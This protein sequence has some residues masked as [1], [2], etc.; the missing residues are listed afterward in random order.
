MYTLVLYSQVPNW[1][2]GGGIRG[3]VDILSHDYRVGGGGGS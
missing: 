3:G 2:E 1:R